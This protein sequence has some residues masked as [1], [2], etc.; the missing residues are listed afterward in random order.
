[1]E[2]ERRDD[3]YLRL[4]TCTMGCTFLKDEETFSTSYERG[5]LTIGGPVHSHKLINV[6][7]AIM[8]P[9]QALIKPYLDLNLN[10]ISYC[11]C[12]LIQVS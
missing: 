7:S 6:Y 10:S 12:G 9:V 5:I 8:M 11:K 3:T 2:K 4:C 1:M